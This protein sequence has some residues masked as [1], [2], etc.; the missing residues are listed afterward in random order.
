MSDSGLPA[1][2]SSHNN[3]VCEVLWQQKAPALGSNTHGVSWGWCLQSPFLA[4]ENQRNNWKMRPGDGKQGDWQ[5]SDGRKSR[6]GESIKKQQKYKKE[7]VAGNCNERAGEKNTKAG[8]TRSGPWGWSPGE[9]ERWVRLR[10]FP[11]EL[12]GCESQAERE[13]PAFLSPLK[14]FLTSC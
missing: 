2:L 10:C 12:P 5:S 13:V 3:T 14:L 4:G 1:S 11:G 9:G 6:K 7:E 8:L